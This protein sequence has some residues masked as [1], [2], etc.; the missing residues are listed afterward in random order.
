MEWYSTTAGT[1]FRS[2][3]RIREV[4]SNRK[5]NGRLQN[6]PQPAA[7]G[8]LRAV[9]AYRGPRGPTAGSSG[10]RAGKLN[11]NKRLDDT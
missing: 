5:Q 4:R 3:A 11:N 10:Y 8:V 2:C 7:T 1:R 6:G 9:A